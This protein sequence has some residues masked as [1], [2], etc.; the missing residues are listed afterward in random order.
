[1]VYVRIILPRLGSRVRI[2]SPAPNFLLCLPDPSRPFQ[3]AAV[4]VPSAAR[5]EFDSCRA[6]APSCK[7]VYTPSRKRQSNAPATPVRLTSRSSRQASPNVRRATSSAPIGRPARD[8]V[9]AALAVRGVFA[10]DRAGD[11]AG[12]APPARRSA[13][14]RNGYRLAIE[15]TADAVCDCGGARLAAYRAVRSRAGIAGGTAAQCDRRSR[16]RGFP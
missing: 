8:R 5:T 16:T 4:L 6:A 14:V 7:A 15:P 1:M 11:T 3:R 2:P 13:P 12:G 9:P 10:I